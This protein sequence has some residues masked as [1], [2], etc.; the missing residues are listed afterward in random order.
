MES[1]EESVPPHHEARARILRRARRV[2]LAH[3]HV[4]GIETKKTQGAAMKDI[5][6]DHGPEAAGSSSEAGQGLGT[7]EKTIALPE[8]GPEEAAASSAEQCADEPSRGCGTNSRNRKDLLWRARQRLAHQQQQH[9][10]P[11]AWLDD[12]ISSVART[13]EQIEESLACA[14]ASPPDCSPVDELAREGGAPTI[15]MALEQ[16]VAAMEARQLKA[17]GQDDR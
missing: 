3:S 1:R 10:R 6:P 8:T 15:L 14:C 16:E 11:A 7:N 13:I 17:S 12:E 5:R 2:A 4:P 9:D